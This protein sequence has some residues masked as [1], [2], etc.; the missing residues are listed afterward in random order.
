[1]IPRFVEGQWERAAQVRACNIGRARAPR[2]D[3]QQ[4][5]P[6]DID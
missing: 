3:A 2:P 1:M 6:N 5:L 4:D